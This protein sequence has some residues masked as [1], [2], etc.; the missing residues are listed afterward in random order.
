ML[1]KLAYYRVV[2]LKIIIR[3][4]VSVLYQD[5]AFRKQK[6]KEWTTNVEKKYLR[7][8]LHVLNSSVPSTAESKKIIWVCWLQ[9]EENAPDVVKI[10]LESLR[11]WCDEYK[12]IVLTNDNIK[13]YV[14][15]P[16]YIYRKKTEGKITNTQFSDILRLAL[17]SAHGGMW[18]DATVLLTNKLPDIISK[19][20]FFAFHSRSN[21]KNNSWFLKA[22]AGNLLM[23]NMRKMMFEYWK[24]ENRMLN[25]FLYHLLF[26]LMVESDELSRQ[27][28]N[29][30]PILYDD[31]C[32]DLE[33]N[34]L[35]P[36]DEDIYVKICHKTTIHK[37][38]YKYKKD[39]PLNG[40]FL[41]KL[42]QQ[43][44]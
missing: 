43:K 41:E 3:I 10:C 4:V 1:K 35:K 17:L 9:G 23:D 19:Q 20:D 36:F 44:I 29:K 25:Y 30:V 39:K 18:I 27:E 13:N 34:F 5:K 8:Y 40:T 14:D 32:Y 22:S 21:L 24:H 6:R 37:L 42:L 33:Q 38:S 28:W 2:F 12:I 11:R 31:E 15:I 26:D 16:D 7:R